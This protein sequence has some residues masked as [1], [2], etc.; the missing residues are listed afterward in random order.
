MKDFFKTKYRIVHKDGWYAVQEHEWWDLIYGWWWSVDVSK[1][2]EGAKE[3]IRLEKER[4]V[5]PVVVYEE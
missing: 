4:R 3:I 5:K 2:L 1:S